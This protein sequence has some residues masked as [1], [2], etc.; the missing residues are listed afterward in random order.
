MK[1]GEWRFSARTR[2]LFHKFFG[3]LHE[4]WSGEPLFA[5][6]SNKMHPGAII[7]VVE[8]RALGAGGLKLRDD[9][10]T[11]GVFVKDGGFVGINDAI[12]ASRFSVAGTMN[13]SEIT[14]EFSG[15]KVLVDGSATG[16]VEIA[17]ATGEFISGHILYSIHVSGSGDFQNH[18]GGIGFVAVNKA[19]T[20]TSDCDEDYVPAAE[21]E[22]R[23]AGTL[24][25]A[26][27]C[28]DGTGKITINMNANTSLGSPTITFHY[29]VYMHSMNTITA[30]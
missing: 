5:D 21:I 12:P 14:Q 1:E 25:D 6:G 19:G 20:V 11:Y 9:S 18:V 10:G 3:I 26:V 22:V 30:L 2:T 16:F 15:T 13:Q 17:I 29:T 24:T 28:T 8:V 7:R 23:T 4:F 27:T